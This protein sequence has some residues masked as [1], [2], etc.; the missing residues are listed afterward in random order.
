MQK[1]LAITVLG[2]LMA[3]TML[4]SHARNVKYLLPISAAM[5]AGKASGKLDSS[6]KFLFGPQTYAGSAQKM[7]QVEA[8]GKT[9]IENKADIPSCHAS[10][11]EALQNLQTAAKNA[12]A[13]AVMNIV[14][15]HK[16]DPVVASA[17]EFECRAGSFSTIMMLKGELVKLAD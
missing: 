12:G 10:F 11:V 7:G 4:P 6:V 9:K 15:Y 16:D 8:S 13:S 5:E 1:R 17:T 2:V 14:S 3:T